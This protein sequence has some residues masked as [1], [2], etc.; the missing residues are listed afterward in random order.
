MKYTDLQDT[1]YK[2]SKHSDMSQCV[3]LYAVVKAV[4]R[5]SLQR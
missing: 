4:P 3:N 2:E 5:Q 1:S